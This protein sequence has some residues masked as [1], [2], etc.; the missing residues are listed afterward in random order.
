[1]YQTSDGRIICPNRVMAKLS[2]VEVAQRFFAPPPEKMVRELVRQGKL[3]RQ[4]AKLAQHIPMAQDITAEADSG[5]HT[6]NRPALTLLPTIIALRDEAV[7]RYPFTDSLRVGLGGGVGTPE[8][9]AAAFA[10]GAAYILTGSINQ[11]CVEADTSNTVREMLS[12]TK[13]ADVTMAP[14]ADMF[15]MGVKVQVLKR[16]TMFAMRAA[17]LYDIYRSHDAYNQVPEAVRQSIERDLLRSSFDDAWQSTQRFFHERDPSQIVRAESNPKHKM[18]LVFRSYLG[19]SALWAKRGDPERRMDYQ[20]WCGPA[21]GAFNAWSQGTFLEKVDQRRV[22]VVGLNLLYGAAGVLR[23][24]WLR[25]QGVVLPPGADVFRPIP[26]E[27]M[28]QRLST[29]MVSRVPAD[30]LGSARIA[31]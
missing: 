2:R 31:R 19:Q 17:K 14:S 9:A 6:D 22:A 8:A 20:I 3:T 12:H 27:E 26:M 23:C 7:R 28:R 4:E 21:M 18:A 1:I 30:V 24:N 13:Q 11:A 16:G 29:S 25:S 15:E 5:G 10:M